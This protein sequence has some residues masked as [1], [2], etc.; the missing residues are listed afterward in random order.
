MRNA[1]RCTEGTDGKTW[2]YVS[3][4][5]GG[6]SKQGFIRSDL[7]K[8][9]ETE[10][11]PEDNQDEV[12]NVE[13]EEDK[14]NIPAPTTN[15]EA[16]YTTDENGNYV[17]YLYDRTLGQRYKIDQFLNAAKD[18]Q[19]EVDELS[20]ANFGLKIGLVITICLLVMLGVAI[21]FYILKMR[22]EQEN[23]SYKKPT[24]TVNAKPQANVRTQNP[25][26]VR[27][28]NAVK[29][30]NQARTQSNVRPQTLAKPQNTSGN[31]TAPA[32]TSSA[33]GMENEMPVRTKEQTNRLSWK[34]KNFLEDND[35][36][37]FGFLDFDD[38]E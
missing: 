33:S 30:Q 29:T 20:S 8:I 5:D 37:E 6:A 17:W 3:Y 12:I 32:N 9:M 4:I 2:Y 28:G 25:S 10:E 24:R 19:A 38:D 35:E 23:S 15:Y 18:K 27:S 26:G 14:P 13:E 7:V 1:C 34:A 36:L 11:E 21:A 22:E 16:V 31:K